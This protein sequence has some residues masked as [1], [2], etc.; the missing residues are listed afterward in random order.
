M[1]GRGIRG[2]KNLYLGE[3][4]GSGTIPEIILGPTCVQNSNELKRFLKANGLEDTVFALG[5]FPSCEMP[6]FFAQADIMLVSLKDEPIFSLTAPAKIQAY[7][8]A[9][10][11]ILAMINGEGGDI[12]RN[13]NCGWVVPAGDFMALAKLVETASKYPRTELQRIGMNGF[14]FYERNFKKEVCLQRLE[15]ILVN[16]L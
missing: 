3:V 16:E 1:S 12:I 2:Y 9:G 7:M 10:K 15:K 8:A 11:P 14:N 4:W 6:H 5:Y 13:A